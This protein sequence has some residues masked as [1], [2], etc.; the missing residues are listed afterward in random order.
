MQLLLYQYT[1]NVFY[2]TD[3]VIIFIRYLSVYQFPVDDSFSFRDR[4]FF[5]RWG[6]RDCQYH[7]DMSLIIPVHYVVNCFMLTW[8]SRCVSRLYLYDHTVMFNKWVYRKRR[9]NVYGVTLLSYT[10]YFRI[11]QSLVYISPPP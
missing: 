11:I 4:F 5:H 6:T 7:W 3:F 8:Y 9:C 1:N 10:R 2:I